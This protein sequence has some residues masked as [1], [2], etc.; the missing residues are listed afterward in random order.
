MGMLFLM[1]KRNYKRTM[2][3]ISGANGSIL[4]EHRVESQ[5]KMHTIM[6]LPFLGLKCLFVP[7]MFC[8]PSPQP[9]HR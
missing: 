4:S 3:V 2:F 8:E 9:T 1:C 6:I 5:V 7:D